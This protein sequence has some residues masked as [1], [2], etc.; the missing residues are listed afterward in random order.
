MTTWILFDDPRHA[1]LHPLTWLR[2]A[3]S[4]LLGAET[5]RERWERCVAPDTVRVVCR[6]ELAPL[7]PGRDPWS[8]CLESFGDVGDAIWVSD[9]FLPSEA[10]VAELRRLEPGGT[11]IR[12]D[13]AVAR[14]AGQEPTEVSEAT[15]LDQ[16]GGGPIQVVESGEWIEGLGA[17]VRLQE[18]LLPTDLERI[19]EEGRTSSGADDAKCYEPQSILTHPASQIDHGAVLDA[20]GGPIVLGPGTQVR[21]HTWIEGPFYSGPGCQLLGGKLGGS[22]LGPVCK[23]RG[24]LEASVL[25]GY[26]NKA[27]DGFVGHSYLGEWV[28]LGALTTTS[29]LKNNYGIVSLDV[30]GTV[31]STGSK[32]VGS[33]LG[34]HVKTRIGCLLNTGTIV[35][36]G[37]NLFGEPA[38]G[39]RFVPDFSWG[40]GASAGEYG[41]EKFLQTAELVFGRRDV[42]WTNY[43]RDALASVFEKT[44]SSRRAASP[45]V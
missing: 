15:M 30:G 45:N 40:H 1:D 25:L 27:H 28:N 5:G 6:D 12:N 18:S 24:E 9:R 29:D 8:Q 39:Q 38:V 35:G 43:M 17:L 20:R 42:P 13:V 16:L 11:A 26:S 10:T 36:V 14:R 37:A 34:D 21:P 23:V 41:L 7:A 2:P 32:K 3:S 4:L 33:F 31:V 44:A 19:L 22:S